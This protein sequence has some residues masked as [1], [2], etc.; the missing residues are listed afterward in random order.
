MFA[1]YAGLYRADLKSVL[2]LFFHLSRYKQ[3]GKDF[4]MADAVK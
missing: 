3:K 2:A 1:L 4:V